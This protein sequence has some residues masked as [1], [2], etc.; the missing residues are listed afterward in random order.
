MVPFFFPVVRVNL[1][2]RVDLAAKLVSL[3]PPLEALVVRATKE[4]EGIATPSPQEE[5]LLGLI[6][7]LSRPQAGRHGL[8]QSS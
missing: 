8:S 5:S 3:R 4:P 6:R 2:M 1:E 7:A